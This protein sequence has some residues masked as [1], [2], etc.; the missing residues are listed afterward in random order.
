M[1]HKSETNVTDNY[2]QLYNKT[3]NQRQ[4][5]HMIRDNWAISQT[6]RDKRDRQLETIGQLERELETRQTIRGN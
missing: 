3:N 5:R 2:R 6:I 1:G 4:T